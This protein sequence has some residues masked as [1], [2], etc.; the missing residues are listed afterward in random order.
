MVV[1]VGQDTASFGEIFSGILQ[2]IGRAK[3][4]GQTTMGN[5]EILH[6]YSFVDGSRI[7]IAEERFVPPVSHADWEK[8]G[9]IPDLEAYAPWETFSFENDP[10]IAAALQLLGHK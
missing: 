8:D 9:I 5:V 10:G 4:A 1:L 7:W 3:I 2:D 6:P